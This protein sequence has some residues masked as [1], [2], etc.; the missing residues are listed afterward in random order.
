MAPPRKYGRIRPGSGHSGRYWHCISWQYLVAEGSVRIWAH[1]Q[2]PVW[3]TAPDQV[4]ERS[5]RIW[6]ESFAE[7]RTIP[8]INRAPS[9]RV[10]SFTDSS[11]ERRRLVEGR[12]GHSPCFLPPPHLI[13]LSTACPDLPSSWPFLSSTLRAKLGAGQVGTVFPGRPASVQFDRKICCLDWLTCHR[14]TLPTSVTFF[15]ET[16]TVIGAD[17]DE[18]RCFRCERFAAE[19]LPSSPPLLSTSTPRQSSEPF[20]PALIIISV[21]ASSSPTVRSRGRQVLSGAPMLT[22]AHRLRGVLRRAPLGRG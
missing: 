9:I 8:S 16:P 13:R 21:P 2:T 10:G 17:M 12:T 1:Q 3:S 11:P 19:G 15:S 7:R 22:E 5:A 6:V 14:R 18:Y 20:P 4:A